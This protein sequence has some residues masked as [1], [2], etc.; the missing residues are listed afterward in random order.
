MVGEKHMKQAF[1][2]LLVLVALGLTACQRDDR[3]A[4]EPGLGASATPRVVAMVR[5]TAVDDNTVA[6]FQAAMSKLGYQAGQQVTYLDAPPAGSVDKLE[7]II[8]HHLDKKPDLFLVSSTP[9]T[10]AVNRLTEASGQP[11]VIFAPVNDPLAAGIVAD[12]QHPG[13]HI[14]GIRLPLGDD[15]RLQWLTRI[16]PQAKRVFLPYSADDKSALK[17]VEQVTAVATKLGLQLVPQP[18]PVGGSVSATIATMPRDVEAIFLPRDSRVE[19]AIAEFV[20]VAAQRRLPIAAPSL[21]QVEAGAL[22]SYGFVHRDI[23]RQAARLA[24][25]IFKGIAAGDLPVEM[26][27]SSLSI[28]LVTARQLGI[29]IPDDI[30][31]Q[32]ENIIRE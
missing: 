15:L 30:L 28:N 21:I 24:D 11:P 19:A 17:S 2:A 31:H 9:A 18:I 16:A 12:L 7:G 10:L 27:E 29:A 32:A 3:A 5:L 20:A 14:T 13:G 6:S 1:S 8:R 26:A 4:A 23:G 22:F 25:Q